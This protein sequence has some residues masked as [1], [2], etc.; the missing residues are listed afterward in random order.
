[1]C[2]RD[3]SITPPTES[4]FDLAF[5]ISS[6]I[7]EIFSSSNTGS[8]FSKSLDKISLGSPIKLK[9]LSSIFLIE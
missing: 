8:F 7:R 4:P 9:G 1:M 6:S 5:K 3:S 2:I